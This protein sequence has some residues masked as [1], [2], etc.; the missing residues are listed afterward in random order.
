MLIIRLRRTGKKHEP[1]YRIVVTDPK[2]SV[3]SPYVEMIGHFNPKT[4]ETVLD[5]EKAVEWMNKGAKPTNTVSRIFKKEGL[6]HKHI[7]IKDFKAVSKK[8]LEAEKAA[9][10]IE[11][12]KE[13]AEKEAAKEAFEKKVEQ[14][15]AAQPSSEE[16]LQAAADESISE[17]KEEEAEKAVADTLRQEEE[18]APAEVTEKPA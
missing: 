13:Q 17:I 9:E 11:K 16:K 1:S 3:Y 6:E 5:K 7:I 4:K 10:E 15:K 18:K 12:A 2:K 8:D 14:E